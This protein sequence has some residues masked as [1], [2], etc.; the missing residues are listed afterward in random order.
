MGIYEKYP[1]FLSILIKLEFSRQIFEKSSNTKF[2]ENP[3]SESRAILYERTDIQ[4]YRRTDRCDEA[5]NRFSQ[6]CERA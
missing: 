2:R 5:N 1:L 4:T 6:F 3:F